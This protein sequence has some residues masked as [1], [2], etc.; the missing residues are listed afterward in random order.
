MSVT[1]G[2]WRLLD[3]LV[4]IEMSL[5]QQGNGEIAAEVEDGDATADSRRFCCGCCCGSC[6]ISWRKNLRP[7]VVGSMQIMSLTASACGSGRSSPWH[8]CL[9][10]RR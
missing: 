8:S 10:S 1:H 2:G 9:Q 6:E 7:L 4:Q 3:G 5:N